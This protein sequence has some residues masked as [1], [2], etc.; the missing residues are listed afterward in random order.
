MTR[1]FDSLMILSEPQKTLYNS[2]KLCYSLISVTLRQVKGRLFSGYLL[3]LCGNSVRFESD[4][5]CLY[6][7]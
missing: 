3:P 5:A 1:L 7:T 4:Q 6:L 2:K